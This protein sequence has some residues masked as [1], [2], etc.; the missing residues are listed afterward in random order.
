MPTGHGLFAM[1]LLAFQHKTPFLA[2]SFRPCFC[3]APIQANVKALKSRDTWGQKK[4]SPVGAD[5]PFRFE[6]ELWSGFSG[7]G[8][9]DSQRG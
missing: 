6:P 2:N 8:H 1:L 9:K 7:G 5:E 3:D 4:G